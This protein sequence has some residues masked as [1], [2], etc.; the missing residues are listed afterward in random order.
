MAIHHAAVYGGEVNSKI[1]FC[2]LIQTD[3]MINRQ[4]P[5]GTRLAINLA[6]S[7]QTVILVCTILKPTPLQRLEC[8]L[9]TVVLF[10]LFKNRA[11]Y[12]RSNVFRFILWIEFCF[13]EFYVFVWRPLQFKLAF[14]SDS[15]K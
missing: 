3:R 15:S 7:F 4:R 11:R 2:S 6:I 12:L 1:C 9:A 14:L 13:F 10:D 5:D 8:A